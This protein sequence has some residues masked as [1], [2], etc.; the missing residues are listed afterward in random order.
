MKAP[1]IYATLKVR[2]HQGPLA[3]VPGP[4]HRL[5]KKAA[6]SVYIVSVT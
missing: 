6:H 5:N 4:A 2:Y 3:Q 1:K